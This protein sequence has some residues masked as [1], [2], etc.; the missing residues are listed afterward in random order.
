M[1]MMYLKHKLM[2]MI[3]LKIKK[4]QVLGKFSTTSCY[5]LCKHAFSTLKISLKRVFLEQQII[6][7]ERIKYIF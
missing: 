7:L 2:K 1:F 6:F 3:N 4:K 5:F